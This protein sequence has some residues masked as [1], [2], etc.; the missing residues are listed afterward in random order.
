[1]YTIRRIFSSVI[2]V[3]VLGNILLFLACKDNSDDVI[4]GEPDSS[5]DSQGVIVLEG[6][7]YNRGLIHGR[8]LRKEIHEIVNL[9]KTD[10]KKTFETDP[11]VFISKFL[12]ETNFIPAIKGYTPELFDEVR[13]IADGAGMDFDTIY[14]FQLM[15]EI[16]LKGSSIIEGHCSSMGS[17]RIGDMPSCVAQNM[18]L[19]CFRN[20]FQRTFL[21]KDENNNNEI[22][23]FSCAGLIVLNGVN[24]RAVGICVNAMFQLN[25]ST[26]GL[27]VAFVIRGVLNQTTHKEAIDFLHKIK[28]ASPQN[29]VIGGLQKVSDYECS[30]NKITPFT[31]DKDSEVIYHTNHPL[32][33]DDYSQF[34]LDNGE[35][36]RIKVGSR[37]R[38]NSLEKRLKFSEKRSI[39]LIKSALSS[40]DS[41]DYPVSRH[42]N[43]NS[44]VFTFG[45]TIM[46]LSEKPEFH[47][48]FGPPDVTP[49]EIYTFNQ[50]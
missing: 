49:Y 14:A 24:N 41:K 39:D 7:P 29:Y 43:E 30:S 26:E 8:T 31:P 10:L 20:G 22:L 34:Y 44:P 17:N 36:Q 38:F 16:F 23:V 18:D 47:V 19:E 45:S 40:Q 1:M 15:D 50:R 32:T 12:K 11:D 2:L 13:G 3:F 27:P 21:I 25:F 5:A 4:S 6:S 37:I 48:A 42:C 9:W 35:I 46:V 33:N 28:H